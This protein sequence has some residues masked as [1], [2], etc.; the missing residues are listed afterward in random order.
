MQ[1]K[2]TTNRHK[3]RGFSLVEILIAL[4]IFLIGMVAIASLFPAAAI[5]QRETTDDV[6][7]GMAAQS[8]KSIIE[9]KRLTYATPGVSRPS[10]DLNF[11]HAAGSTTNT[12]SPISTLYSY[13]D[14]S[15][16]TAQIDRSF[17]DN[18]DPTDDAQ[19]IADCDLYWVPFIQDLNGDPANPN[20]VVR[21]FILKGDSRATYAQANPADANPSD[22][23]TFPKVR[24]VNASANGKVF[25]AAGTD[26]EPGDVFMDSNGN[27]HE[28]VNVNG[29]AIE[30]VNQIPKVLPNEPIVLWYAPKF[31]GTSSPTQRIDT[32]QVNVVSP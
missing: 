20:W 7:S 25:T 10:A 4:G 32:V 6:I 19:A 24:S 22:P 5:I 21:L 3:Q 29:S 16:P 1:S 14:R 31:G 17:I 26:L 18:A 30:V 28:V 9:A 2:L 12:V 8:A 23:T 11:Y 13:T 15:Y 27:S